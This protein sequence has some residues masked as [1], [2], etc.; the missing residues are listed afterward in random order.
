[1]KLIRFRKWVCYKLLDYLYWLED[2]ENYNMWWY[3]K[4]WFFALSLYPYQCGQYPLGFSSIQLES[5]WWW[6]DELIQDHKLGE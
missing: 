1:M 3:K 5:S 6:D 2:R 4:V